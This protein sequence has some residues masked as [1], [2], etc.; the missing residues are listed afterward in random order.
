[1]ILGC[2]LLWAIYTVSSKPLLARY[3]PLELTAWTMLAG[4]IPLVLVSIPQLQ[5]QDWSAVPPLAWGALLYSAVLSAT[6]G[7]VVWSLSV[8]RVGNA[9]TAIYSNLTPVIAILFAWVTLGDKLA[10]V[11][12]LGG[13]IV[14]VGLLVTRRGRSR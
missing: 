1:M 12:L 13:S 6:V 5:R 4:T 8:Q 10:P 2:A 14:L 3:S 11:Q 7:Y 9:R